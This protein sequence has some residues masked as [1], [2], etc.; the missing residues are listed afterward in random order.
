VPCSTCAADNPEVAAYCHRC[1][2]SLRGA[3]RG[4]AYAIQGGEAVGQFALISTVMPH[5]SRQ[6]AD[7]YRWALIASSVLILGATFLAM[8]PIAV[9]AAAFLVP[10]TYLVYVYDVNLWEDTPVRF[11]VV[12]FVVTGALAV[13]VS[14]FFFRWVFA[15]DFTGLLLSVNRGGIGAMPIGALLLFAVVLPLVAEVVKNLAGIVLARMPQFDD[16]VDGLTFGIAS[17]TAYAAFETLILFSAVF[18]SPQFRTTEGLASWIAVV[19]NLMIVKSLIYGTA[20]GIS[21]ATFSG[22]GQ[23]YDGFT[24]RYVGAFALAAGA[25]VAYW[26]GV[27]LLAYVPWGQA[28]GVLWGFVILAALVIRLRVVMHQALLE[29]AVEDAADGADLRS[30]NVESFCPECEHAL[31]AGSQFCIVCG[32]S[33]RS[34]SHQNRSHLGV[35]Q[36]G[37]AP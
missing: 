6:T 22:R 34:T 20:T 4:S 5:T 25:N 23:G 26:L 9:A 13:V 29:A 30:T 28:L 1:G 11:V 36:A 8:L 18:T 37:G 35:G 15:D 2:S 21:V 3:G 10:M 31:L 33:V 24:G 27:R 32:T 16:M 12:A 7:S 19:V 17:G 14:L